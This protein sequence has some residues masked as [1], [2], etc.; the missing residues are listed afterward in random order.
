MKDID[1]ALI[2]MEALHLAAHDRLIQIMNRD[3]NDNGIEN[4]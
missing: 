4:D 1:K 3:L 2:M